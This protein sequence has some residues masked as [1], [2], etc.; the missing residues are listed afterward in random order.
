MSYC[1]IKRSISKPHQRN[2]GLPP[3]S[4]I[5]LLLILCL[6]TNLLYATGD[7]LTH[8]TRRDQAM[9]QG[10]DRNSQKAGPC[11]RVVMGMIPGSI[12]ARCI[13]KCNG[14]NPCQA[15]QVRI[16][17]PAHFADDSDQYYPEAWRCKCGDRL[18]MP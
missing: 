13:S 2:Q 4:H 5:T 12:P 9:G 16:Q 7:G 15:V 10:S 11:G 17:P 3:S 6:A 8:V 1:R 14:C 18:Y